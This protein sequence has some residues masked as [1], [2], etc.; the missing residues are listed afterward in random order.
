MWQN[1]FKKIIFLATHKSTFAT[2]CIPALFMS[3]GKCINEKFKPFVDWMNVKGYI[4]HCAL[5]YT[6]SI[7][8][9]HLPFGL[10]FQKGVY[11]NVS[12]FETLVNEAD[13]PEQPPSTYIWNCL[14]GC[15]CG[16]LIYWGLI[17]FY[18]KVN[19]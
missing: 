5:L 10:I 12:S 9:I 17:V 15:V 8:L 11:K 7:L 13:K 16:L 14:G 2:L 4:S 3:S 1:F 19:M 18:Y 6:T